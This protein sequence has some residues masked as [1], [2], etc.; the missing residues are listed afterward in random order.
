MLRFAARGTIDE[1]SHP[2]PVVVACL[3]GSGFTSVGDSS[4]AIA[5]GET[6]TWPAGEQHRLW[7]ESEPMT[8]LLLHYEG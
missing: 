8:C 1:H 7:T 2:A 5:A 4:G 3:E 6:V